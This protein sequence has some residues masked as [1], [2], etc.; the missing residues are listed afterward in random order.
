MRFQQLNLV[1]QTWS[2]F[3]QLSVNLI[4]CNFGQLVFGQTKQTDDFR[5]TGIRSDLHGGWRLGW[6]YW[7]GNSGNTAIK[8][9]QC[10]ELS[11]SVRQISWLKWFTFLWDHLISVN[12]WRLLLEIKENCFS[13]YFSI[14]NQLMHKFAGWGF[15]SLCFKSETNVWF[16]ITSFL[17]N[18]VRI[19]LPFDWIDNVRVFEG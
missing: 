9:L 10:L 4:R 14:C 7:Q 19:E 6:H 18:N 17:I 2:K 5:S 8:L 3:G 11:I 1:N 12:Y 15:N 13:I 16:K